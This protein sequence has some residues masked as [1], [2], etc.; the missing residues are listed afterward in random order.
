MDDE[1]DFVVFDDVVTDF[2]EGTGATDELSAVRALLGPGLSRLVVLL[3]AGSCQK[4]TD[5][6]GKR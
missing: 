1:P 3:T 5:H 4:S 2:A 6:Q